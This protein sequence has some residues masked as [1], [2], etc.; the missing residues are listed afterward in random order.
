MVEGRQSL[1]SKLLTILKLPDSKPQSFT[2]TVTRY[3]DGRVFEWTGTLWAGFLFKGR[4]YFELR[5]DKGGTLFVHGEEFTGLLAAIIM[6]FVGDKTRNGFE[7]MNVAFKE[8]C[9]KL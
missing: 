5:A 4:H 9:E 1:G 7:E 2:P 6:V 3:E 8:R